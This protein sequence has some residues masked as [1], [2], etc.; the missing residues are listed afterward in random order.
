LAGFLLKLGSSMTTMNYTKLT[1]L[2]V[3]LAALVLP[4]A[5]QT[6]GDIPDYEKQFTSDDEKISYAIGAKYGADVSNIITRAE[7]AADLQALERGFRDRLAANPKL[8]DEQVQTILG[9]YQAGLQAALVKKHQAEGEA[10]RNQ[11][12]SQPGIVRTRTGLL[13]KPEVTGTGKKPAPTDIVTCNFQVTLVNGNEVDNSNKRAKPASFAANSVVPGWAEALQMMPVGSKWTIVIPPELAYGMYGRAPQVGPAETLV[14]HV[15]LL[16]SKPAPPPEILKSDIV[17]V[18]SK[19]DLDKGA[20]PR[21]LETD[22]DKA[23][24]YDKAKQQS[25]PQKP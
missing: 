15:E 5:A 12:S 6:N 14:F 1:A 11:F 3:V 18:P 9:K 13:I 22:G 24:E 25:S 21:T 8:T 23:S 16:D 10:F 20:Q 17:V 7:L 4:A 2:S 19:A